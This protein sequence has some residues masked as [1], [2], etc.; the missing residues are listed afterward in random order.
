L[1][2]IVL[3]TTTDVVFDQRVHRSATSLHRAGYK[4]LVIGRRLEKTPKVVKTDY[5]VKLLTM[6]FEYGALFYFFFNMRIFFRLLFS[7]FNVLLANDLD[8]LVSARM[9]SI[10]RCKPFIYDSHEL[11]T[12][13]PELLDRPFIRRIWLLA[14]KIFIKGIKYPITVSEG[15]AAEYEKRYGIKMTV[16]RNLPL[17]KEIKSFKAKQP[18]IIYQGALNK[19]RGIE[20]AIDMMKYLNC[21]KLIIVGSGDIEL[22]L[23]KRMV[24][25]QLFDRVEF[26]GR[27]PM[28]ELHKLTCSAWLGLSLEEDM[29]LS[30][31]NALPNKIF[32]YILAQVP[33]LV[34]NLPEM[35]KVVDKY[36]VGL[37]INTRD[38]KDLAN[39]IADF[40]EDKEARK[41][42]AA[43]L[44]IA[45][46]DLIWE[47]EES[48]L[49]DII[50]NA[51]KTKSTS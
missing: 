24:E 21:Y 6:Y 33:I 4:V 44:D 19:G 13:V 22:S 2:K 17:Y 30:Y 7:K 23:R 15:V 5:S 20:L 9:V 36:G 18:I 48:L 3:V 49:L 16:I 14:E 11:F 50:S 41:V 45:S 12:E 1:K 37:V 51:S 43:N 8:T 35:K 26:R 38:P 28:D 25:Q 31:H 10:W 39:M 42:I 46:K 34:S 47:K 29:G 27:T 32:D 40:F